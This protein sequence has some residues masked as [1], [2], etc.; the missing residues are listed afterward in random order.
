M[1]NPN[2]KVADAFGANRP[3]KKPFDLP[4]LLTA[5]EDVLAES[6]ENQPALGSSRTNDVSSECLVYSR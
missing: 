5:I 6:G 1:G 3:F 2:L 4:D